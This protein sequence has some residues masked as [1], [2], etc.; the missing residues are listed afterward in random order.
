MLPYTYQKYI[1][2]PKSLSGGSADIIVDLFKCTQFC[3]TQ[4]QKLLSIK[5]IN[6]VCTNLSKQF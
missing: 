6:H 3:F 2:S 5:K 1:D 4:N